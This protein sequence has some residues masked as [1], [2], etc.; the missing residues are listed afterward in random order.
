MFGLLRDLGGSAITA[1]V[2]AKIAAQ[3]RAFQ[4]R[5]TKHRYQYQMEDMRKAGLNPMLAF[6]QSP[7]AAPPGAMAQIPDFGASISR[8][9]S[10]LAEKRLKNQQTQTELDKQSLI[11]V[12]E[13]LTANQANNSAW[14]AK[15]A[16]LDYQKLSTN[17][18]GYW[19]VK[20]GGP[21]GAATGVLGGAGIK[22]GQA[23]TS[24]VKAMGGPWGRAAEKVYRYIV[25][26]KMN[27]MPLKR[28]KT[29]R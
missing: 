4:E 21:V 24:A 18:L 19:A 29:G 3:N 26:K 2:S 5:M 10:A 11:G 15:L 6:G 14:M 1:G 7:P 12:Q 17:D 16:E 8:G 27:N 20:A 22:A 28:G 13:A 23:A 9:A 25:P